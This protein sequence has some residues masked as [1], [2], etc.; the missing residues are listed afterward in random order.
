M[1][2]TKRQRVEIHWHDILSDSSWVDSDKAEAVRPVD[3]IS[4]GYIINDTDEH[5][6]L[7]HS[8]IEKPGQKSSDYTVIPWGCV[9]TIWR[10]KRN[11][12]YAE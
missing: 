3:V 9:Q 12:I 8:M 10:L 1:K 2:Q 11:G 6:V 7:A 5:I 4:T